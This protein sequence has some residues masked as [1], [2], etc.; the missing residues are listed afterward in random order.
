MS[1]MTSKVKS[2]RKYA[3]V[4]AS[5][6]AASVFAFSPILFPAL[7]AN[8]GGGKITA[9]QL[10]ENFTPAGVDK[11]LAAKFR[12]DEKNEAVKINNSRFAFT[13][14]GVKNVPGRTMTIA[15]RTDS[16][17]SSK[18]VSIR[19]AIASSEA[20][21]ATPIRLAKSDFRLTASKGWK[22]FSAPVEPRQAVRAPIA[23]L[24]VAAGSFRLE[25]DSAPKKSRFGADMRVAKDRSVVPSANGNAAAGD[26][27]VDLEGSF[28]VTKRVA[29]T[30]GVR[31]QSD[32]DRVAPAVSDRNDSEAVYVGTKIRF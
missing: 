10:L 18:A 7:A 3:M 27:K 32:R 31:Y 17:L 6:L 13:P 29:V 15:A 9:N 16:P 11:R 21:T 26:Y 12:A 30:A 5:L 1:I 22:G 24:D 2:K 25:D 4:T 14:A 20:G 23:N 19:S 8:L 28:S